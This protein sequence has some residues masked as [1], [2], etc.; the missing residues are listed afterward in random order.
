MRN[1]YESSSRQR[2]FPRTLRRIEH[3]RLKRWLRILSRRKAAAFV[4]TA[5]MLGCNKSATPPNEQ[6]AA[7]TRDTEQAFE[8]STPTENE[9][10]HTP[11]NSILLEEVGAAMGL[12]QIYINGQKGQALLVETIGGGIGCLDFNN[13]GWEDLFFNQGGDPQ[14]MDLRDAPVDALWINQGGKQLVDITAMARIH[15]PAYSQGV[16][17]GDFDGDGFED[18]YVTND[19]ANTLWWNLGDGTFVEVADLLSI[20]D[21]RWSVSAAWADLNQDGLLDLYVGNYCDYDRFNPKVCKDNTGTDTICN[22]A[23]LPAVPDTCFINTGTGFIES[24][25]RLG[26]V[27]PENRALGVAITDFSG[28]GRPDI[29]VANDTTEN[30]LFVQ[31]EQGGFVETAGLLGCA[32][33]RRGTP[34]GSMGLAVADANADGLPDIYC[35]NYEEEA[36]TLYVNLGNQGFVDQTSMAG[37]YRPTVPML[38][39]GAI[40]VDLNGDW[41]PE[42]FVANGHVNNGRSAL[43]P[44]MPAQLF[45]GLSNQR[46]REISRDTSQYFAEKRMGRGVVTLDIDRDHRSDFVIANQNAPAAILKNASSAPREAITVKLVGTKSNR[47][48]VGSTVSITQNGRQT[49][50]FIVGG[51]SYAS[52][53]SRQLVF[54]LEPG[55]GACEIEVVWPAGT[56]QSL[57]VQGKKKLALVEPSAD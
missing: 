20:Q 10:T 28:D 40:I 24:S 54:A 34:Q 29:Y 53:S 39:F 51:G 22:P 41:L 4:L 8:I 1:G 16:A 19:G 38:G 7:L 46:W 47:D 49:S 57:S 23:E 18:I 37:L 42:I 50:Q 5:A 21:D 6:S 17:V 26:L 35:T 44:E 11:E 43:P 25:V 36:N 15:D 32:V 2:W 13:D 3:A 9:Q 12:Q 56:K 48:A 33:D 45:T 31:E 52:T 55:A 27:G 30:F 14:S